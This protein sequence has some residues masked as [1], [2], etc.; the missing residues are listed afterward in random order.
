VEAIEM[1][2]SA[3]IIDPEEC[4]G[5][6]QCVEECPHGVL[7]EHRQMDIPIKCTLCGEC[8]AICPREALLLT[9]DNRNQQPMTLK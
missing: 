9:D 5:C 4:T 6:M 1:K 3:F 7:F 2:D 8:A